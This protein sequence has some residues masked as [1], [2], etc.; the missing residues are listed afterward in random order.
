MKYIVA[1]IRPRHV[2]LGYDEQGELRTK[3]FEPREFV[4]KVIKID[5]ILSFTE[6]HIFIACPHETVQVW[7]YEGDL[8]QFKEQLRAENLLIE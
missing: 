7:D 6:D 8:S 1:R 3:K 2:H 5:R 4:E